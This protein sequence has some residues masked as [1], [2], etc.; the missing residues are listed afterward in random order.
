[1]VRGWFWSAL[2]L[3]FPVLGQ[4]SEV[5]SI[6]WPTPNPAWVNNAP[7]EDYVQPTISGRVESAFFGCVR[8]GGHRFHEG[9]DLKSISRDS[10][11][12]PKDPVYAVMDG[13]V[14]HINEIAGNSGYGRY[15]VIE[16]S[17]LHP[18]PITL[19]G[20][21]RSVEPGIEVGSSV[22]S[23]QTIGLMGNTA[24]GYTIP[25]ARAHLHFE[26]GFRVSENFGDWYDW[27]KYTSRNTHGNFNGLNLIGM[28]PI[29]FYDLFRAGHVRNVLE[30]V[31][32]VP[33]AF[34]LRV[35]SESIPDFVRRYPTL[36]SDS[37]PR[38]GV[39]GWEIG[40]TFYGLPKEWR[41]LA[42]EDPLL[43]EQQERVQVAWF[44]ADILSENACR[45]TL[46][47]G[48][49][50]PKIG[51]HTTRALQLLFGFR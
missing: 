31:K 46:T 35:K 44:D 19:Y 37:V 29:E 5:L 7:A 12:D 47:V 3:L 2:L 8:N 4:G 23:G 50:K 22:K 34:T 18:T 15:I 9:V 51:S 32:S 13:T 28:N 1:M 49:G 38:G 25:K 24:G 42:A 26:I 30:Y 21:L 20:H 6:V 41:P 11:R 40:F 27:K 16:H 45:G 39:G 17:H 14:V 48:R 10:K 43:I 33:V 36:L